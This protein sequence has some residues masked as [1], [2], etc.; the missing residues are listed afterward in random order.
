MT[1]DLH[2][3]NQEVDF[4]KQLAELDKIRDTCTKLLQT[5]HYASIGESGI[6]AIMA[7]SKALGIH[8]FEALN[9]GFFCINGKVGMSTEMM[10]ALI[11]QRGHSVTKDSKSTNEC[12]ILHGKRADTG[13]VWTCSFNRQD[14][15]NAGLWNTAVWK[16]Y[17]AIMLYNRCMS[18]LFRQLFSDLSLGAGYVEDELREI[19]KTGDYDQ[20]LQSAEVEV[21]DVNP[22]YI[23]K[24]DVKQA[25]ELN[26]LLQG[27]SSEVKKYFK[28]SVYPLFNAELIDD[29]PASSFDKYRKILK[30]RYEKNQIDLSEQSENGME[31]FE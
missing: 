13:D 28:E 20:K 1:V 5:K 10:S 31:I 25:L 3:Q 18:M 27:C 29:L 23:E 4:T 21:K 11:R 9:G 30:E 15:E 16:K 2:A 14:A 17:P 24:L 26:A 7:R 22:L 12:I 19:T 6:H 8:P